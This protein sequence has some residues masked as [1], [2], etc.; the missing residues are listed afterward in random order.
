MK[1]RGGS[2]GERVEVLSRRR[3]VVGAT[4]SNPWS[5]VNEDRWMMVPWQ[6][7]LRRVDRDEYIYMCCPVSVV[8][9]ALVAGSQNNVY[10]PPLYLSGQLSL[11]I[12]PRPLAYPGRRPC[13]STSPYK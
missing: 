7:A 9:P 8:L 5:G 13:E 2:V 12:D 1:S 10:A 11:G 6:R 4:L 3:T